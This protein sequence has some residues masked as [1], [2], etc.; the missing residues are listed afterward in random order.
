MQN[1][2]CPEDLCF[3]QKVNLRSGKP[4]QQRRL[5]H[6]APSWLKKQKMELETRESDCKPELCSDDLGHCKE[7]KMWEPEE[8]SYQAKASNELQLE[9]R[10]SPQEWWGTEA[11]AGISHLTKWVII[12]KTEGTE[13]DVSIGAK[14]YLPSC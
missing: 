3:W 12:C 14:A 6:K 10:V 8:T 1:D 13:K 11:Q 7:C 2:H 9:K 5:G 4:G